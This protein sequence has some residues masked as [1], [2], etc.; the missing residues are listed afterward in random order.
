MR[1]S[2][3]A[4][5][6]IATPEETRAL[7]EALGRALHSAGPGALVI[8]IEGELGAGK[9]TLVSG[10]LRA[11]G[12]AGPVRSP[13]YTLVEP[14]ETGGLNLYHLDLYRLTDAREV[15]AL[16]VRDLLGPAAV[17]LI[18]WPS[19]GGAML[20]QADLTLL[21]EYALPSSDGRELGRVLTLRAISS[22]GHKLVEQVLAAKS[23]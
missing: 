20:P 5:L 6:N 1:Q 23:Q 10:V 9:T 16:G 18:E 17:L 21:L 7:G 19:R 11:V 12:V 22:A 2:S 4:V 13:T 8:G 14:Y 15:E 3:S